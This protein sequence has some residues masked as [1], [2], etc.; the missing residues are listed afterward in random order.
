MNDSRAL[1]ERGM[2]GEM[3]E[4]VRGDTT[5]HPRGRM[6]GRIAVISHVSGRRHWTLQQKPGMLPDAPGSDGCG[7]TTI[8]WHEVSSDQL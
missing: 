5:N 1:M 7:W 2:S 8:D 6:T 4:R 3:I